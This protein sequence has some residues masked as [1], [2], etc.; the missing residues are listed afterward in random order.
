MHRALSLV[1]ST[2]QGF[3]S[4]RSKDINAT[5]CDGLVLFVCVWGR[6][7]CT[8]AWEKKKD[9]ACMPGLEGEEKKLET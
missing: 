3:V 5:H 2:N 1:A 8:C 4:T 6:E 9:F 7:K